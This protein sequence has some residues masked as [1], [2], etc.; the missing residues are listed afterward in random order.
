MDLAAVSEV[1]SN[2]EKWHYDSDMDY[3]K[4]QT[5]RL[6]ALLYRQF[7]RFQ[8]DAA[9]P[10]FS[11]LSGLVLTEGEVTRLFKQQQ[12]LEDH[13]PE[14]N[15]F[16]QLL[17]SLEQS[18]ESRVNGSKAEGVFLSLPYL[19]Q[20]FQLKRKERD[21]VLL[22]L[23]GEIE[24]KYEKIFAYLQNDVTQ[25]TATIGLLLDCLCE[26]EEERQEAHSLFLPDS[27]LMKYFFQPDEE[28]HT[29]W[30]CRKVKLS[31][32]ILEFF[33]T[34]GR[35]DPTLDGV[36]Q[37]AYPGAPPPSLLAQED[38]QESIRVCLERSFAE[39]RRPFI[40]LWGAPGAGK[41]L[42]VKHLGASWQRTVLFAD[43]RLLSRERVELRKQ[44]LEIVREALIQQ[45]WLCFTHVDTF[46]AEGHS[47]MP[48]WE[49]F[50]NCLEDYAGPLFLLAERPIRAMM[51]QEGLL[52][53]GKPAG[54]PR[55][56]NLTLRISK[57]IGQP[58]RPN[59]SL[60][61][62]RF[63]PRGSMP[64]SIFR[65]A[66]RRNRGWLSGSCMLPA[67]SKLTTI[68]R[69]KRRRSSPNAGG[70]I[71]FFLRRKRTC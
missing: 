48:I 7:L 57:S 61:R 1:L 32:R 45:G 22:S 50:F 6:N 49:E 66:F 56:A 41:K 59:S 9:S 69:K 65:R 60:R 15:R 28:Q 25:K 53:S 52:K 67:T 13:S 16:N 39:G 31:Q 23:A 17:Q 42:Q 27:T 43:V 47:H 21:C 8:A 70:R 33:L 20:V 3:W 46:L 64:S 14:L 38:V 36:L 26:S 54:K 40:V 12:K 4:E 30:L 58:S 2:E 24:R 37:Y 5:V 68:W 51:R 19:F 18:I 11:D 44:L 71:S 55:K 63:L 10:P 29:S 34:S 35:V 62:G